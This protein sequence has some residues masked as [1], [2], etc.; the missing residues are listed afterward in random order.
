MQKQPT[1]LKRL[2]H[3]FIE[4]ERL[5]SIEDKIVLNHAEPKSVYDNYYSSRK[6]KGVKNEQV[7]IYKLRDEYFTLGFT[8]NN[9]FDPD[10]ATISVGC[11]LF[12]PSDYDK[13]KGYVISSGEMSYADFKERL[14]KFVFTIDDKELRPA[15]LEHF[16]LN[17]PE[18]NQIRDILM[19]S[20]ALSE[21]EEDR[22]EFIKLIVTE[23]MKA[24]DEEKNAIKK[25]AIAQVNDTELGKEIRDLKKEI[26]V[27]NKKLGLKQKENQE[28]LEILL[29]KENYYT[30]DKLS[31]SYQSIIRGLNSNYSYNF[32]LKDAEKLLGQS[33][34]SIYVERQ[35]NALNND[36]LIAQP[37]ENKKSSR[38]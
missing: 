27:L 8:I 21:N 22:A 36:K 7:I 18:K 30:M 33:L 24:N 35:R 19:D 23:R 13:K 32:T 6:T 28:E 14:S 26:E 1:V 5:N 3:F 34:E 9:I 20:Y 11:K 37:K 16:N 12:D 38:I 31:Q 2:R 10:K 29:E 17:V 25:K 15:L 4:L